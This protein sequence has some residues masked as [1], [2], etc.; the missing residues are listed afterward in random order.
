MKGCKNQTIA[1][2]SFINTV[3]NILARKRKRNRGDPN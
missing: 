1:N 2:V 3:K